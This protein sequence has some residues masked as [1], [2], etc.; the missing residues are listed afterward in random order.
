MSSVVTEKK[1]SLK[2]YT[3]IISGAALCSSIVDSNLS[4]VSWSPALNSGLST[5]GATLLR[6]MGKVLYAPNINTAYT[7][8]GE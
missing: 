5:V 6:D 4:T 3:N 8:L 2:L 7:T 1:Q